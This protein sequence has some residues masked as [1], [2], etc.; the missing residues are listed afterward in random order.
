MLLT[1]GQK[2][3]ADFPSFISYKEN[4]VLVWMRPLIFLQCNYIFDNDNGEQTMRWQQRLKWLLLDCTCYATFFSL[5]KNAGFNYLDRFDQGILTEGK[6]QYGWPPC[7][8]QFRSPAF[9]TKTIFFFFLQKQTILLRISPSLSCNISEDWCSE[10]HL[11]EWT[12]VIIL[13]HR[14]YTHML[15]VIQL[16][17]I[18]LNI[19]MLNVVLMVLGLFPE[20]AF[21][22][23]GCSPKGL[24]TECP[25]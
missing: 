11:T 24:F 8:Y 13:W 9:Y 23:K 16:N 6:D 14:L 21:H 12:L 22:R 1:G 20:R 4:E 25:Y 5:S 3:A 7:I 2:L 19:V 15:R 18:L 10:W 17:I